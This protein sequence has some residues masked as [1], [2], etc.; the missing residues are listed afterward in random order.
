MTRSTQLLLFISCSITSIANFAIAQETLPV[1][2]TE[3]SKAMEASLDELYIPQWVT[4]TANG[5][6]I[7]HVSTPSEPQGIPGVRVSLRMRGQTVQ[8]TTSDGQGNFQFANV[9]PNLYCVVAEGEGMFAAFA[10]SVLGNARGKHLPSNFEV[11]VIRPTG[12]VILDLLRTQSVPSGSWVSFPAF[13]AA[14]PLGID[15]TAQNINPIPL[16][17]DGSFSGTIAYPGIPK[18]QQ[19]MSDFLAYLTKDGRRFAQTTVG[20]D[21]EFQFEKVPVGNYG[22]VVIG[23]RGFGA[24]GVQLTDARVAAVSATG[25]RFIS[26]GSSRSFNLEVT[27][28]NDV[29]TTIPDPNVENP[30]DS[31]IPMGSFGGPG[32]GSPF[33]GGGGAGGGGGGFGGGGL[34]AAAGLAGIAAAIALDDDNNNLVS[35]IGP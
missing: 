1:V 3:A 4:P 21:G 19:D 22:V 17:A 28:R 31:P 34:F 11:P 15:R 20:N 9:A 33:G 6:I 24:V 23:N 8:S 7:G 10:L 14:D 35:P 25:Q 12:S 29:A 26:Q 13:S 27:S 2:A 30:Q 16:N 32:F 5:S 18:G